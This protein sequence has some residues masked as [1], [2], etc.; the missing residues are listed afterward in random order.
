MKYKDISHVTEG[1]TALKIDSSAGKHTEVRHY[2]AD[3]LQ[4][5][6]F[7]LTV[8]K[9]EHREGKKIIISFFPA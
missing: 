5:E 1:E 8:N 6:A 3:V 9:L 7:L 4:E 2:W